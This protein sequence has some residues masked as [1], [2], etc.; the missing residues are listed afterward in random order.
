MC[1]ERAGGGTRPSAR[2]IHGTYHADMPPPAPPRARA[3]RQLG[4]PV[5]LLVLLA[6]FTCEALP[7]QGRPETLLRSRPPAETNACNVRLTITRY[8]LHRQYIPPSVSLL[9]S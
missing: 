8:G 5:L 1:R 6:T 4:S 3:T 7:Q 2:K 9:S